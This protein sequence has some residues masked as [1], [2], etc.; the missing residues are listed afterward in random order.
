MSLKKTIAILIVVILA[1]A[2]VLPCTN[3]LVTK[4]AS[5]DGSVMITYAADAHVL[6]GEL[7]YTPAGFHLPGTMLDIYDWDSGK[8]LGKIKQAEQTFN[9]VGNM[10]ENQVSIGETTWGGR[11]E[12]TGQQGIMDYGSLMYIT[13]QRAQTARDAIRIIGTLMD[14]YGY[15]SV[16]ESFS[17]SD[18]SS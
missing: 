11:E 3:L 1:A 17:V 6:Y 16:G 12:L 14:E 8:Y 4:G 18:K 15:Y 5:K 13:L 7:Y 10:N 2:P 9:V